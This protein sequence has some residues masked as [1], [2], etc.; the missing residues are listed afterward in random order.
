MWNRVTGRNEKANARKIAIRI[1][2]MRPVR[3]REKGRVSSAICC[4][5]GRTSRAEIHVRVARTV[6]RLVTNMC[7][8]LF[9]LHGPTAHAAAIC[10]VCVQKLGWIQRELKAPLL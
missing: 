2:G 10:Q 8:C 1:Q 5:A 6:R 4:S 3:I 9:T 7:S